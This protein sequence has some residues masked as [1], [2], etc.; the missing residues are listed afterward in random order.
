[1]TGVASVGNNTYDTVAAAIN[2]AQTGQT[3]K[4]LAGTSENL[5]I[6]KGITFDGNGFTITNTSTCTTANNFNVPT[7]ASI[8]ITAANVVVQNLKFGDKANIVTSSFDGKVTVT[9]CTFQASTAKSVR[10]P[11][12]ANAT[13]VEVT[14]NTFA[15]VD[16][17]YYDPIELTQ[18]TEVPLKSAVV[19][20]NTFSNV[21]KNNGLSVYAYTDNAV[22]NMKN[23]VFAYV[24]NGL[25]VSNYCNNAAT[26]N[27]EGNKYKATSAGE[28]AGFLL[29][30]NMGGRL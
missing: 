3:V 30:Q 19:S 5:T 13:E 12:A 24:G 6:D 1:M 20:N 2:A 17:A 10:T 21:F 7:T 26:F 4:L 8:K 18:S 9:G 28:Y 29:L 22:I 11:I 27:V 16:N 25:R 14:N 15:G 23:N